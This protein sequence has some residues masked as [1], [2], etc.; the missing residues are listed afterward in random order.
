MP[1]KLLYDLK[2]TWIN[3]EGPK[4][5]IKFCKKKTICKSKYSFIGH[6]NLYLKDTY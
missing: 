1:S 3:I 4:T 2:P 5:I 6:V